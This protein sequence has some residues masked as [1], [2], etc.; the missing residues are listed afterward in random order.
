MTVDHVREVKSLIN[1]AELAFKVSSSLRKFS[2]SHNTESF[3]EQS[4]REATEF[5][6]GAIKAGSFISGQEPQLHVNSLGP[7][8]WSTDVL[9]S[10]SDSS[11]SHSYDKDVD[12]HHIVDEIQKIE[13]DLQRCLKGERPSNPDSVV[14]FFDSLGEMLASRADSEMAKDSIQR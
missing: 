6:D 13:K 1:T 3:D 9:S 7:L 14:Q 4:L 12:Y 2:G 10:Q 8:S 11:Q 5:L